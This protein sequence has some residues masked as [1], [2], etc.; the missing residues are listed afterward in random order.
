M[1]IQSIVENLNKKNVL[2]QNPKEYIP[3]LKFLVEYFQGQ[4]EISFLEIGT[5]FGGNFVAIGNVLTE[6]GHQVSGITIDLP[7]ISQYGGRGGIYPAKSIKELKPT[8]EWEY[9]EGNSQ[10]QKVIDQIKSRRFD[11]IF[12][13]GDHSHH[14][15][16]SDFENY[17]LLCKKLVIVHD[18]AEPMYDVVKVWPELKKQGKRSW[19][20]T[21]EGHYGIGVIEC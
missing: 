7:G 3:F 14:G 10:D 15:I 12:I 20:F 6:T 13:D 5:L 4:K 18:I 11:F 21:C 19:E 2:N 1:S 16:M 17:S 9:I 8:F